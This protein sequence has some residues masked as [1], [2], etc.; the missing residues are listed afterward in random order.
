MTQTAVATVTVAPSDDPPS[1][2]DDTIDNLTEDDAETALDVLSNDQRDVNNETFVVH[3]VGT[4]DQGGSVRISDDASQVLYTPAANFNGTETFS[5]TIRDEGGGLSVAT[6]TVT[7]A[8]V[9]DPPPIESPT[10]NLNRATGPTIVFSLGDLA[11]NVDAAENLSISDFDSS[12]SAGGTVQ[13]INADSLQY[14]LPSED[15][16]GSDSFTYQISDEVNQSTG[17]ISL[18][19]TDFAPRDVVLNIPERAIRHRVNGLRI[20]GTNQLGESV[21]QPVEYAD[22]KAVFEDL[23][24]GDYTIQVPAIPFLQNGDEAR[25]ISFSSNPDDGDAAIDSE[26]GSLKAEF[27][28]VRDWLGSTSDNSVLLVIKPGNTPDLTVPTSGFDDSEMPVVEL[29]ENSNSVTIRRTV[30][31]EENGATV[32]RNEVATLPLDSSGAV[33]VRGVIAEQRL[34]KIDFDDLQFS[35]DTASGGGEG[36]SIA[37]IVVSVGGTQAEGESLP[38]AVQANVMPATS[39][40]AASRTDA[41]V[42]LTEQGDLWFAQDA[43]QP[44]KQA[45][46]AQTQAVD[47]AM[48]DVNES[49]V[50]A[51]SAGDELADDGQLHQSAIDQVLGSEL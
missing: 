9:N 13:L 6:V 44:V 18:S 33:E 39:S 20:V 43:E 7:V 17:T 12:T 21:D 46:E 4:P 3:A 38:A 16:V 41:T 45:G 14:T 29:D 19:V 51:E 22:D 36:E 27:I 5:Y 47:T 26:L 31:V 15:F 2:V 35:E 32:N 11:L 48:Q 25:E 50:I 23:L 49:L 37:P 28:T 42:L 8:A 24:P 34:L 10:V 30:Q 40:P 1:A